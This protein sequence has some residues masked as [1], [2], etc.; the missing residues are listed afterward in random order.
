MEVTWAA[1][2]GMLQES[3]KKTDTMRKV[4]A[5]GETVLDIIF[6]EN[7]VQDAKPGGAMLNSAVS[8]GRTG[9]NISLIT[10]FANDQVGKHVDSFLFQNNVN[11]QNIY[12]HNDGKTAIA[13]AFLNEKNDASYVFYKYHPEKRLQ[14]DLPDFNREDILLFGSFYGIEP[15]V[16]EMLIRIVE[17]AKQQGCM[18]VYDPNF[19][20]PHAHELEK[21]RP[22]ILENIEM[23]DVIRGSDEDFNLIFNA[24]TIDEV[25]GIIGKKVP[26]IIMT[27]SSTAVYVST[28]K[29]NNHFPVQKIKPLS[30]IG[31][32]DNFNA[33]IIYGMIRE[34]IYPEYISTLD[35]EKWSRIISYGVAFASDVCMSYENYISPA[36]VEELKKENQK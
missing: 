33:G 13:M 5:I 8:L 21:L 20:K 24:D 9:I 26:G 28:Q 4:Y 23:A 10:E 1:G 19:R 12:R 31:A 3:Q 17:K 18:I 2:L 29:L 11:T 34:N 32:G 7:Q 36:L 27:K 14:I 6:K 16:R 30:T 25:R 35:K 22:Y 15:S